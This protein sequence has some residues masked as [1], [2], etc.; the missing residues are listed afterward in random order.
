MVF[1]TCYPLMNWLQGFHG[2]LLHDFFAWIWRE[3]IS[4][5]SFEKHWHERRKY[6]D[7][8]GV[9]IFACYAWYLKPRLYSIDLDKMP[10]LHSI[11][12]DKIFDND[13]KKQI[14][15]PPNGGGSVQLRR[16]KIRWVLFWPVVSW[17][18][19]YQRPTVRYYRPESLD[20]EAVGSAIA[21]MP[22][23]RKWIF[24]SLRIWVR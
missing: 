8:S 18:L 15:L 3:Y 23:K 22:T 24:L 20:K 10:A 21:I 4:S 2:S 16:Y 14:Q 11:D 17:S 13:A 7:C 1:P 19:F 6:S 5:P 9:V 12:L